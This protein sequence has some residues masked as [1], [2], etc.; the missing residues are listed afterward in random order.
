M[1][2]ALEDVAKSCRDAAFG[3]QDFDKA[4]Q[5]IAEFVSGDKAILLGKD[6]SASPTCNIAVGHDPDVLEAYQTHWRFSDPRRFDSFSTPVGECALGQ[7]YLPN[8]KLAHTEY[9]S[10]V[11]LAGD[12]ADSVHGIVQDAPVTGRLALSVHRGFKKEFFGSEEKRKMRAVLPLLR[13]AIEFSLRS[14]MVRGNSDPEAFH[15]CINRDLELVQIG[16]SSRIAESLGVENGVL[17][18][19]TRLAQTIQLA[20]DQ[21][22]AGRTVRLRLEQ[23]DIEV[24]PCPKA[25]RWMQDSER[26]ALLFARPLDLRN[27]D[28]QL[29]FFAHSHGFTAREI[30]VFLAF[31]QHLDTRQTAASLAMKYETAR[32]HIKNM[33]G[34]C[35]LPSAGLMVQAASEG[36]ISR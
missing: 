4:L 16:G 32:W 26:L 14:A 5:I 21:A 17:N 23:L 36:A 8:E 33:L 34:K 18:L 31:S 19:E 11:S 3:A 12:V 25:L 22:L 9:F 1:G 27:Q 15:T 20:V 35:G 24:S 7:A 2:W 30:D 28:A 13:D 29:R 10:E 6:R